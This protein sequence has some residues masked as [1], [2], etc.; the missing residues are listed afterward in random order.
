MYRKAQEYYI[1]HSAAAIPNQRWNDGCSFAVLALSTIAGLI[2]FLG[3]N[4]AVACATI[5]AVVTGINAFSKVMDFS[6]KMEAHHLSAKVLPASHL[7]CTM[8]GL[9]LFQ[10]R[11]VWL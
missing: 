3:E 6:R 9:S 8:D 1:A 4:F 2:L 7:V 11:S 5:T 10:L